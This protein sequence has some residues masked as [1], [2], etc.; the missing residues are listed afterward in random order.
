MRPLTKFELILLAF[1]LLGAYY[2]P[3]K[4]ASKQCLAPSNQVVKTGTSVTQTINET[5]NEDILKKVII[6]SNIIHQPNAQFRVVTRV[7]YKKVQVPFTADSIIR[8]VDSLPC[9]KGVLKLPVTI[10]KLDSN[11]ILAGT[12]DSCGLQIDSLL[13][14]NRLTITVGYKKYPWYK[15]KQKELL[16]EVNNSNA[17]VKTDSLFNIVYKEKPAKKWPY[18]VAGAIIG[19]LLP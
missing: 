17:M 16:L 15:F 18:F 13:I 19:L 6:P 4:Q 14:N 9:P 12:I 1:L 10:H 7:V 3:Q 11:F 8:Q 2:W 5:S